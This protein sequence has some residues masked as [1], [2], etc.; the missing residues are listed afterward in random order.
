MITIIAAVAANG[1]IGRDNDLPWKIPGDLPRFKRLTTGHTLIMGRK[2]FESIGKPLPKRETI[3]VSRT[4]TD[5]PFD[6]VFVAESIKDAIDLAFDAEEI[7]ICGGSRVYAETVGYADR[8]LLTHIDADVVGDAVFPVIPA[9]WK[10]KSTEEG[11]GG[12]TIHGD[13]RGVT[14]VTYRYCEYRPTS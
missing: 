7:F 6:N 14:P 5:L 11:K 9:Q 2:T 10:L 13:Y 8:M 3:V 1:V 4:I 12:V